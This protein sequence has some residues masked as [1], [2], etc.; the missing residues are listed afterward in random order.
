MDSDDESWNKLL[1]PRSCNC[2]KLMINPP[3]LA[4]SNIMINRHH[5]IFFME[6][7]TIY[8]GFYQI[9]SYLIWFLIF[10]RIIYTTS[11]EWI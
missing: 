3:P 10:R 7:M 9:Q 1:D 4:Y 11:Y 6:H 5:C 8:N 2:C